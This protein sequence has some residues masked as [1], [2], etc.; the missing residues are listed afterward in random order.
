MGSEQP[1][2]KERSL[3]LALLLFIGAGVLIFTYIGTEDSKTKTTAKEITPVLKTDKY[4]K[5]VNKHLMLTNEKMKLET[6][7]TQLE[8]AKLLNREFN[9]VPAQLPYANDNKLD[10]SS[11]N[12][13][14]EVAK[15]LGRGESRHEEVL[16]PDDIVQK[17]LFNQQQMQE[18]TQAY[19][20]EYAR[21]FIE[22]AR[23]GGYKVILSDDLSR[24]ISVTPLRSPSQNINLDVPPSAGAI[25]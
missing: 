23:R 19:K 2:K 5:S 24:V 18:Y 16:T 13:A 15:D 17:E 20:E 8:N 21:Q 7:R 11:D 3:L 1:Q 9:T 12:R 6:Q 10:L 22:N 14:A 25:H 4:E